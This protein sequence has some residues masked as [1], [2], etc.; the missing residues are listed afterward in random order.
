MPRPKRIEYENALYHVMNRGR[1]RHTIFHDESYYAAFLETLSEVY[2]RFNC[3]I[4][5]YCLMGNHYHIL[6]ETPDANLS[7]IMRHING[8]YTQRYNRLKKT[9]GPLFRG[10]FKAILVD[11]DAYLLQLSRYIHRNPIDMKRP[12]VSDL[13]EYP[14]SSY[15]A[16]INKAK[17]P[18]WLFTEQTYRM[19]GH[20][21]RFKGYKNYV[22][23]GTDEEILRFYNRGNNVSI[24]ADDDFRGWVFNDLLPEL[25]SEGKAAVIQPIMPIESVVEGVS[26]YYK[27]NSDNLRAVVRGPTKGNEARKIAMY[28]CQEISAAKLVD[29]AAYFGL[30]NIGSV[31]F[32]THQIRKRKREDDS[33]KSEIDSVILYIIRKVT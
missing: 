24:V 2:Q 19:L 3:I 14:W 20:K 23:Q 32:I 15:P 4:H 33:F 31:S 18:E 6:L 16:Y 29:I 17:T 10:R 25:E 1:D 21:Q 7:R 28:L 11:Q 22:S 30:G 12:M 26:H 8:V 27:T 9:E 13:S 5:A